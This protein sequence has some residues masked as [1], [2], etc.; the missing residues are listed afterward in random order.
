[1]TSTREKRGR[2]V[3]AVE[4]NKSAQRLINSHFN[5][6][7]RARV[8]IPADMRDDDLIITDFIEQ[9]VED[10]AALTAQLRPQP[11]VILFVRYVCDLASVELIHDK[12]TAVVAEFKSDDVLAAKEF[13]FSRAHA[14]QFVLQRAGMKVDI[15]MAGIE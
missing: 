13:A 8:S 5:N 9:S 1:M 4:A 11:E 7:D 12:V 3:T 10:I 14:I 6:P 15:R 2:R